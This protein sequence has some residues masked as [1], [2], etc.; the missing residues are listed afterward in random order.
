M[1]RDPNVPEP[2]YQIPC[3]LSQQT[4]DKEEYSSN[5]YWIIAVKLNA[6]MLCSEDVRRVFEDI[7]HQ[8]H[9]KGI[10]LLESCVGGLLMCNKRTGELMYFK[11]S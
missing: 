5:D 9:D 6:H 1:Q 8:F 11:T 3:S 10:A 2:P 7:D 4:R